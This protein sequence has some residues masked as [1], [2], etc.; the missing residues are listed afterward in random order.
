M[1]VTKNWKNN[2][3]QQKLMAIR[4]RLERCHPC[5]SIETTYWLKRL[6]LKGNKTKIVWSESDSQNTLTTIYGLHET[7]HNTYHLRRF[8]LKQE[9][10]HELTRRKSLSP[11]IRTADN[12]FS[13]FFVWY[14]NMAAMT[15]SEKDLFNQWPLTCLYWPSARVFFY[16]LFFG[17]HEETNVA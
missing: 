3:L 17:F 11:I 12:L 10:A 16:F 14:T 9:H 5:I 4:I 1:E 2:K 6:K 7:M 13:T 15:S 8:I